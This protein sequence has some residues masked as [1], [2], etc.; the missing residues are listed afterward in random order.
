VLYT[1][2]MI[3]YANGCEKRMLDAKTVKKVEDFVKAKPRSIQE[4]AFHLKKNWRTAD[5]YVDKI[6][7][8]TGSLALRT[9]REGTRGALK[10]AYWQ[11]AENIHHS[12]LQQRLFTMIQHGK[13]KYDFSPLEIYQYVDPKKRRAFMEEQ[14]D[15]Q[16]TIEHELVSHLRSAQKQIL[17]FSGNLSFVNVKQ[18]GTTVIKVLEELARN[19]VSIKVLASLHITGI[20]NMDKINAVNAKLGREAIEVRHLAQPL[21]SFIIDDRFV[22]MKE[23]KLPDHYAPEELAKRTCFFYEIHD[24]DWIEWTQ[25]VFWNLFRIATP[26]QKR[27]ESLQDI[28]K[29]TRQTK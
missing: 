11:A 20:K 29:I 8:E 23:T 22:R 10:I 14:F 25:K 13:T 2:E 24:K 5:R 15:D 3:I 27:V 18:D 17:F 6:A 7:E 26:A 16:T 12:D 21:R 19:N 28:Q 4:I 9:F 1:I